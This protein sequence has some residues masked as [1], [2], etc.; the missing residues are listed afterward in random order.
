MVTNYELGLIYL[1]FFNFFL[2][3]S[4]FLFFFAYRPSSSLHL[5]M[6]YST[7]LTVSLP[8]WERGALAQ[9]RKVHLTKFPAKG[10]SNSSL[11]HTI[12]Q[13]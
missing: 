1:F 10:H 13:K 3:A 6:F 12:W 2:N 9:G 8:H 7:I 11:V 4:C 5:E